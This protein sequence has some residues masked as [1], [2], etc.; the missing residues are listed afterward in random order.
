MNVPK[1]YGLD[2]ES[3]NVAVPDQCF[4]APK[5]GYFASF[6]AKATM[7]QYFVI[8]T[9]YIASY[10]T[11]IFEMRLR[12]MK[13]RGIYPY[14]DSACFCILAKLTKFVISGACP[15]L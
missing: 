2:S 7:I 12:R 15:L 9:G 5:L 10:I 1:S 8:N 11:K 4:P 13:V 14:A 6:E 3:P